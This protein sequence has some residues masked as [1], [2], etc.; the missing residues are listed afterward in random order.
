[1]HK[2]WSRQKGARG[3]DKLPATDE[4]LLLTDE[5]IF[6]VVGSR[7]IPTE[8]CE[9]SYTH[10]K[11][12]DVA[13]A[14]ISKA[15]PIIEA[16]KDAECEQKIKEERGRILKLLP[17]IPGRFDHNRTCFDCVERIKIQALK[18]R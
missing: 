4:E 13:N 18:G 2:E 5:E 8:Y 7:Y 6:E 14:A 3:I 10:R 16:R 17:D 9:T 11:H 1:M 12:R 15:R